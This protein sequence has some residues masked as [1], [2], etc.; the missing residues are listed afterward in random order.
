MLHIQSRPKDG[1]LSYVE[2]AINEGEQL[3]RLETYFYAILVSS[4]DTGC[5]EA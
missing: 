4:M 1:S 5:P 2:V 3:E